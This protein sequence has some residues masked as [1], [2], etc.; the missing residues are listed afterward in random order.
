[1]G[2]LIKKK[3]VFRIPPRQKMNTLGSVYMYLCHYRVSPRQDLH[4][5]NRDR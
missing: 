4:Y 3:Q 2:V 1:M 5:A